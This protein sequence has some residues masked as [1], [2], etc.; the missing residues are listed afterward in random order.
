MKGASVSELATKASLTKCES[1][2]ID[3]RP[4]S[5]RANRMPRSAIRE[6][7]SLAAGRPDV[8][9][10]EVGEPDFG[11]PTHIIDQAFAAVRAG[12]TRYTGNAGRPTLRAA[13]AERASRSGVAVG[14]ERVIVTV[15]AIGGTGAT[16]ML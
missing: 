9:H 5:C 13:I 4:L 1:K 14:P 7:M 16:E 8:I 12:A 3:P 2:G 11:T 10:L 15:G 6:I